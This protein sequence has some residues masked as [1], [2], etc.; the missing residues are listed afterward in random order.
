MFNLDYQKHFLCTI[1]FPLSS[2][3]CLVIHIFWN[4]DKEDKIDPPIHTK[5][6]L[7]GGAITFTLSWMAWGTLG[8]FKIYLWSRVSI[9]VNIVVP[10][11]ITMF[12]YNSLRTSKSHFKIES[13]VIWGNEGISFPKTRGLNKASGHLHLW[14]P[15]VITWPSGS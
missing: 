1:S 13:T 10:P 6:F 9:L 12:P 5:N 14:D 15:T 4:V 11:D 3:S 8:F 2:Y 7:S